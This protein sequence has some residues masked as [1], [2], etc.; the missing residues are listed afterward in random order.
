MGFRALS[1]D[2]RFGVLGL[3]YKCNHKS[4]TTLVV[5]SEFCFNHLRLG[6]FNKSLFIYL[7]IMYVYIYI[8]MPRRLY[9]IYKVFPGMLRLRW[10]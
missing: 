10:L 3:A 5:H 4:S 9:R 6:F 2:L 8:Y 1:G 7:F